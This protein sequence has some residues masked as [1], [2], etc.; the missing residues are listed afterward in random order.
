MSLQDKQ[1][2]KLADPLVAKERMYLWWNS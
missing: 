2:V 1:V